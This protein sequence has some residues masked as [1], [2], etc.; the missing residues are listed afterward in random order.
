[1]EGDKPYTPTKLE[2]LA[3][4]LN[5][6]Y[7]V[8]FHNCGLLYLPVKGKNTIQIYCLYNANLPLSDRTKIVNSAKE[9][10]DAVAEH[11]GWQNWVK[12]EVEYK[13]R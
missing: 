5:A 6:M 9:S 7:G 4:Q 10:V 11:Y 3:L 1:M 2:W 13:L 12:T 8:D